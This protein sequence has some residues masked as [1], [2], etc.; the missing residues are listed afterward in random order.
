MA[1]A[2]SPRPRSL[3]A[4]ARGGQATLRAGRLRRRAARVCRPG[5]RTDADADRDVASAAHA[6]L[7]AATRSG[8]Q[9]GG[10]AHTNAARWAAGARAL[11]MMP[12]AHTDQIYGA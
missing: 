3:R 8:F 9:H 11:S 1:R 4:A 6:A 2:R 10:G 7:R 12:R 5:I